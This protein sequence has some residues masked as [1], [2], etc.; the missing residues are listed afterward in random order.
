MQSDTP[1]PGRTPQPPTPIPSGWQLPAAIRSRLGQDAGPQ[2]AM[3]E[4]GHLLIILHEPPKPDGTERQ[5][6]VFWRRPA[7]D[8]SISRRSAARGPIA[9][10]LKAY[11]DILL[12]LEMEESQ[13]ATAGQFHD[14]LEQAAPVLRATR[15]LHRAL[16]QA[17]EMVKED[18]DLI[19]FRD[20][21]V[22]IERTAELILQDAQFGMTF[23]AARQSESQAESARSMATT[24]H[25]LNIMAALFLP[26]TAVASI[27]SMDVHSG[28][29][30]T[31]ENFWLIVAAGFSLGLTVAIAIRK[32]H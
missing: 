10:L 11:E 1:A 9:E 12:K 5:P 30:N 21:A 8:W 32:R 3:L 14:V 25:R 20:R 2:R 4:E 13:A 26:V 27:L 6:A 16:Q 24:A 15:G 17:R 18:R 31:R 23:I 28:I 29:D 22:A 7:G 19:N